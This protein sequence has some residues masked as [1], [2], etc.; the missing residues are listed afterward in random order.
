ML[1]LGGWVTLSL[2][3]LGWEEEGPVAVVVVFC[4]WVG[5]VLS[6]SCVDVLHVIVGVSGVSGELGTCVAG[7]VPH[8]WRGVV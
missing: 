4:S 3:G 5:D 7:G 8:S 2:C 1:A 6:S